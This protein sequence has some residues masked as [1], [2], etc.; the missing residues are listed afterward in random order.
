MSADE[1]AFAGG[2]YNKSSTYYLKDNTNNTWWTLSPSC[3]YD[4]SACVFRV[5]L[6]GNLWDYFNYVNL[7]EA[8]R[9]ALVL[10]S[11]TPIA[12]DSGTGTQDN[13]YVAQ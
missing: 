6:N 3:F 4:N 11:T 13:P 1:V 2:A 7:E 12:T 8:I 5:D 9:P 10:K